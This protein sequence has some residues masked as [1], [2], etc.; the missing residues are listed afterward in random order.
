MEDEKSLII[1][2]IM[3]PARTIRT[4]WNARHR[5]T[6]KK[7]ERFTSYSSVTGRHRHK[8]SIRMK[9]ALPSK[10]GGHKH[11]LLIL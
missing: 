9:L 1:I 10:R 4:T 11:R 7:G 2:L 8:I 5:H 3:S 6:F